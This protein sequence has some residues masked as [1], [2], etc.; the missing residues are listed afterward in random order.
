[1]SKE[2]VKTLEREWR[3]RRS[4]MNGLREDAKSS[5]KYIESSDDAAIE[6]I[7]VRRKES[8]QLVAVLYFLWFTISMATIMPAVMRMRRNMMKQIQRFLRADRAEVTAFSV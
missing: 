3:C 1:M 4:E 6:I 2:A 8:A 5:H 7:E